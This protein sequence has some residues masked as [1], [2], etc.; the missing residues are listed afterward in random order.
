MRRCAERRGA[1]SSKALIPL[2]A[3]WMAAGA[4]SAADTGTFNLQ[5][6]TTGVF[7]HSGRQLALDV[8]GHDDIANI[9]FVVGESCVAVIDTGGS[10]TIGRALRAAIRKQTS[11]PIC[12]VVNTHVHVDHVLGNAA[13]K[14]DK[15][16]FVGHAALV[17][18]M[19]RSR[20][21]FVTE[22]AG[23]LDAPASADQVISPD[24]LVERALT[25]DLGGRR[26]LLRAWPKAHTD[27]DLT[28]YDDRTGTLW[29]GD[30]LFRE[31]LPALDGSVTGWL[32]AI[33]EL[34]HMKI[35]LA[36]PGHGP[37]TRNLAA[38]ALPESRYLRSLVDGVRAELTK[39]EPVEDAIEHVGLAEKTHWLLWED[40]HAHNV[41]RVYEELEWE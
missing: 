1:V 41:L 40:A 9:G 18:A 7:L 3:C 5:Q 20:E 4:A 21:F 2:L 19:A 35:K 6:L 27:C 37:T 34:A 24:R 23:D 31:R 36:V 14:D 38:A 15:P 26:L 10:V 8:P 29:T 39:G 12:Y 17:D 33:D 13:F 22:Y 30:L 11:L 25:L 28:V 16:S 32:A